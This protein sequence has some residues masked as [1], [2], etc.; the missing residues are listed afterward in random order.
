MCSV[1]CV[2]CRLTSNV[3]FSLV[4]GGVF[5]PLLDAYFIWRSLAEHW[6]VNV[7]TL[8][9]SNLHVT[10]RGVIPYT[11]N[12]R[13]LLTQSNLGTHPA[14]KDHIVTSVFL[15][16]VLATHDLYMEYNLELCW[17]LLHGV[18]KWA[19]A[20]SAITLSYHS[21]YT[22]LLSLHNNTMHYMLSNKYA[23]DSVCI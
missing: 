20:I 21:L 19:D 18:P 16:R 17:S 4:T 1:R 8:A 10:I 5:L 2:I 15:D 23:S 14:N 22:P 6:V 13:L 12:T 11:C 7:G 9:P 3:E